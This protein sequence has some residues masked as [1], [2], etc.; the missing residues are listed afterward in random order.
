MRATILAGVIAAATTLA[1]AAMAQDL[2]AAPVTAGPTAIVGL[3]TG[4]L[5]GVPDSAPYVFQW[6]RNPQPVSN[7][8][9]DPGFVEHSHGHP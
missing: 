4:G 3:A 2:T 8:T 1:G 5:E 9:S 7:F 6:S